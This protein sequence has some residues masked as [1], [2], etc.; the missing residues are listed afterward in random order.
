[1]LFQAGDLL[2]PPKAAKSIESRRR[3]HETKT[4]NG[5]SAGV[6][7]GSFGTS[8]DSDSEYHKAARSSRPVFDD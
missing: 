8:E 6:R 1:M 3:T 7:G 2:Q 4:L 5:K